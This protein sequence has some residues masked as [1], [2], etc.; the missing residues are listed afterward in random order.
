MGARVVLGARAE[1]REDFEE[2]SLAMAGWPIVVVAVG[3]V[4]AVLLVVVALASLVV[5]GL[6][7]L[8]VQPRRQYFAALRLCGC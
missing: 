8:V 4:L 3:L 1:V 6:E 5:P 2:E 7:A